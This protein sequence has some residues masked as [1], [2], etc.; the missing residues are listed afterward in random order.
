MFILKK[1]LVLM[2]V[3][4]V[5]PFNLITKAMEN[6]YAKVI[7]GFKE[8][9]VY[10]KLLYCLKT[11]DYVSNPKIWADFTEMNDEI[12]KRCDPNNE[13]SEQ[14][15]DFIYGYKP[16]VQPNKSIFIDDKHKINIFTDVDF[17][18]ENDVM[19]HY[20]TFDIA[21]QAVNVED[22]IQFSD[23]QW[24][25]SGDLEKLEFKIVESQKVTEKIIE[26]IRQLDYSYPPNGL[27]IVLVGWHPFTDDKVKNKLAP[28]EN[29]IKDKFKNQMG[30]YISII[31]NKFHK[32]MKFS[33]GYY[34]FPLFD[35]Y[36]VNKLKYNS[37][38]IF[39]DDND[40]Y[41]RNKNYIGWSYNYVK[42]MINPNQSILKKVLIDIIENRGSNWFRKSQDE[43]KD[44]YLFYGDVPAPFINGEYDTSVT[45]RYKLCKQSEKLII[46]ASP[47]F[48]GM[49][50]EQH[51]QIF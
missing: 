7:F 2:L 18:D 15:I 35:K 1:M 30:K 5:S 20:S 21:V 43:K 29:E 6:R 3:I 38:A 46:D 33:I 50:K 37:E 24:A 49:P 32:K 19:K 44:N 22:F 10:D 36:D 23:I 51:C 14:R 27:I 4:L 31:K 47:D 39:Q 48:K 25:E 28:K 41:E 45:E 13:S 9:S 17:H 16:K 40:E 42:N 34:A 8:L 12:F 11:K 26:F